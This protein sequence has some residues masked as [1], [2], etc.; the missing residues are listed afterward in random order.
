MLIVMGHV[1]SNAW[2]SAR[3]MSCYSESLWRETMT[4]RGT[5]GW[6]SRAVLQYDDASRTLWIRGALELGAS[7]EFRT[8]LLAHPATLAVGLDSPGGYVEEGRRIAKQI[9]ALKLDTYAPEKCAS[10]CIDVFAAGEN[11]WARQQTMFG[12]HRSGHECMPDSGMNKSDLV[13]ANFL[14]ERGVAEDFVQRAF[15][16]PFTSIWKPDVRTVLDGGLVT[17]LR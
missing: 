13:A 11:R 14:R 3:Q 15:E 9:M 12:F 2:S 16:T 17:G 1:G 4:P 7:Q 5:D 10:A 8:A 6:N